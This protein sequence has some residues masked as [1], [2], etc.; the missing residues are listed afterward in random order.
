[1]YG[2]SLPQAVILSIASTLQFLLAIFNFY[3]TY[4]RSLQTFQRPE[5]LN[6]RYRRTFTIVVAMI[7]FAGIV[8][9]IIFA[10]FLWASGELWIP[11]L[12]GTIIVWSMIGEPVLVA[13]TSSGGQRSFAPIPLAC[14]SVGT[15]SLFVAGLIMVVQYQ[16]A[17]LGRTLYDVSIYTYR[18]WMV[19]EW[20]RIAQDTSQNQGCIAI[21]HQ[22]RVLVF[23]ASVFGQRF[24]TVTEELVYMTILFVT[25]DV[26][27]VLARYLKRR[28][29]QEREHPVLGILLRSRPSSVRNGV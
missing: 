10:S 22:L 11:Y 21:H 23:G 25:Y 16:L 3:H 5:P 19:W 8:T 9:T 4:T 12:S 18:F 1:M 7:S 17:T 6:V 13:G 2:P 24:N 14:I 20:L 29:Y 26:I 28:D 15:C 27:A